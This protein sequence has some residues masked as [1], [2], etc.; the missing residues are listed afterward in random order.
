MTKETSTIELLDPALKFTPRVRVPP[1]TTT[2]KLSVDLI[3]NLEKLLAAVVEK[4]S[5]AILEEK[6]K[7]VRLDLLEAKLQVAQFEA[8]EAALNEQ[9]K[10]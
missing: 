10:E 6:L 9:L 7:L 8:L 4:A 1:T 5:A 2:S 3:P